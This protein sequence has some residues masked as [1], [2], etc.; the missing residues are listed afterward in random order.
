LEDSLKVDYVINVSR[1]DLF[2]RLSRIE[3][4]LELTRTSLRDD[5]WIRTL[6]SHNRPTR[7]L[8]DCEGIYT[9]RLTREAARKGPWPRN[10]VLL[11]NDARARI[12]KLYAKDI[13]CYF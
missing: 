6:R 1:E 8:D 7:E 11:T 13:A 3:D 12:A 9:R 2:E 5:P 10:D 4:E